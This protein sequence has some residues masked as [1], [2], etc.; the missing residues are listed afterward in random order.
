MFLPVQ[1]FLLLMFD[2][3]SPAPSSLSQDPSQ[4][5]N[6]KVHHAY[7]IP[8][9]STIMPIQF[10]FCRASLPPILKLFCFLYKVCGRCPYRSYSQ[11]EWHVLS[12]VFTEDWLCDLG[13]MT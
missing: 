2:T 11:G 4:N 7:S 6:T 8:I 3:N 5:T 1:T 12:P 9:L 10:L 13:Q